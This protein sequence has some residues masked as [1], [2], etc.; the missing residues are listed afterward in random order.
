MSKEFAI[1]TSI[2]FG[3][4]TAFFVASFFFDFYTAAAILV[5]TTLASLITSFIR[6]RR[7]AAFSFF[8]SIFV[9]ICGT[10][11]VYFHDPRW[12]VIEYTISN[13][14][15]AGGLLGG[16]FMHRPVLRDLFG[17]MFLI[18]EQGWMTLTMRWGLCFLITGVSNQLWWWIFPD[19]TLWTLFRFVSTIGVFVFGMCQFFTSRRERL[20][21]A[22]PWGLVVMKKEG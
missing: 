2:E 22:S 19:E 7:F 5:L 8:C 13:L 6:Y 18:T 4:L 21:E 3:P 12:I 9:L 17:H 20:P 15:F 1:H 14:L 10:A 11:T 16:W